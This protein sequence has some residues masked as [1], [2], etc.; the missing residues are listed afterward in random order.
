MCDKK[1]LPSTIKQ[2]EACRR[3]ANLISAALL[4]R[5][6]AEINCCCANAELIENRSSGYIEAGPRGPALPKLPAL[7]CRQLA[8]IGIFKSPALAFDHVCVC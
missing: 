5:G 8:T 3:A 6:A 1:H 4:V 2:D 7:S